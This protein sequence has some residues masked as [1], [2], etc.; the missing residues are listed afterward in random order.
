MKKV[1]L[2][3]RDLVGMMDFAAVE[4]RLAALPGVAGVAMNA[5]S[6][7]ATVEFDEGR[8][9]P[10]ALARDIEACGFHCRGESVP[11][12]LCM[13]ARPFRPGIR[14]GRPGRPG[15]IMRGTPP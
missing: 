2:E 15:M 9:S 7:T 12:H 10:G 6:T 1:N 3:V 14:G 5:G 8:T 11:R 13:I 4:K